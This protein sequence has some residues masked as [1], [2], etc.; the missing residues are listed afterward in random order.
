MY[1][2]VHNTFT[3][4]SQNVSTKTNNIRYTKKKELVRMTAVFSILFQWVMPTVVIGLVLRQLYAL[5]GR[6]S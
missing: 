1:S 6:N 3:H 2:Q 4:R 5:L